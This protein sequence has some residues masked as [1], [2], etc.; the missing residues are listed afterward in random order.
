M[1]IFRNR[2][3]S[4]MITTELAITLGLAVVVAVI[5]IGMFNENI[6]EM[7]SSG[8]FQNFFNNDGG[9]TAYSAFN[10]DYTDS[11]INVQIMGAQGLEMLRQKANNKVLDLASTNPTATDSNSVG[12]LILAIES[13]VG[14]PDI[15]VRMKKESKKT[16]NAKDANI[17]GYNYRVDISTISSGL[18]TLTKSNESGT[19]VSPPIKLAFNTTTGAITTIL[20]S[21]LQKAVSLGTAT[22]DNTDDTYKYI[23]DL[24]VSSKPYINSDA[25]LIDYYNT[26]KSKYKGIVEELKAQL[27]GV[28]LP[29]I[30]D[31]SNESYRRCYCINTGIAG[32]WCGS[33]RLSETPGCHG[34]AVNKK[35]KKAVNAWT[36]KITAEINELGGK[37]VTAD[38]IIKIITQDPQYTDMVAIMESDQKWDD[39]TPSCDFLK[40]INQFTNGQ[41][42][43]CN[44][45]ES[46]TV[47]QHVIDGIK[48]IADDI[49]AG[50]N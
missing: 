40:Q 36:S 17:G 7:I 15:C 21:S 10:R 1:K 2:S 29:G 12:Y 5:A 38:Q 41:T 45:I 48:Q 49:A 11:Q 19:P 8:N 35:E 6:K 39:H 42:I 9:K 32:R 34:N 33:V 30:G 46:E 3:K 26:A 4:A 28:I 24:S 13:I 50:F 27:T 14:E 20:S 25:L 18:I 47:G 43:T 31:S 22:T 37:Q 23:R 16:C 44:T